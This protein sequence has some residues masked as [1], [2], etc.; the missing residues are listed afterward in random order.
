M[1]EADRGS[2]VRPGEVRI[3]TSIAHRRRAAIAA[4]SAVGAVLVPVGLVVGVLTHAWSVLLLCVFAS[5]LA[6][7]ASFF[8]QGTNEVF[9]GP[10]G[11]R[12]VYGDCDLVFTWPSLQ[13]L[14]VKVPGN[15]IVVF[16]L[17]STGALVEPTRR[18]R[19]RAV[20]ALE[21]HPPETFEFRLD[22]GATDALVAAIAARRPDIDGLANWARASRPS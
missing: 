20:S 22:R 12:R 17:S 4:G 7:A 2:G 11:V 18:G 19:S 10:E 15:R 21:R 6:S 1:A 16:A 9:V 14:E 3:R 8:G 5:V 13:A